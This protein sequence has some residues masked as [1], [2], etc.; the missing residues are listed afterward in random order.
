MQNYVKGKTFDYQF[1]SKKIAL[2]N[3]LAEYKR[4]TPTQIIWNLLKA[5]LLYSMV[6][7]FLPVSVH[8]GEVVGVPLHSGPD[9]RVAGDGR[10]T[11]QPLSHPKQVSCKSYNI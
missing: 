7:L 9:H 8:Y 1:N 6:S 4:N 5:G 10:P 11:R 3:L 2:K